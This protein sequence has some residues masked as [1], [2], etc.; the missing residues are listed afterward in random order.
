MRKPIFESVNR[1]TDEVE[2]TVYSTP[3]TVGRDKNGNVV[4]DDRRKR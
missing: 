2:I 3:V 4:I 1:D